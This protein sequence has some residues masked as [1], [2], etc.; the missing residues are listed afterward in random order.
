M[1]KEPRQK[2]ELQHTTVVWYGG[3][4]TNKHN[5]LTDTYLLPNK[6]F[7]TQ[8]VDDLA[9]MKNVTAKLL[10]PNYSVELAC[11][12][13]S[14][15]EREERLRRRREQQYRT[16]INRDYIPCTIVDEEDSSTFDTFI[17]QD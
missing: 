14:E 1:C 6:W 13:T 7:V 10:I 5:E 4:C 11:A 16:T 12:C 8:I 15:M 3:S 17:P 9:S 2:T